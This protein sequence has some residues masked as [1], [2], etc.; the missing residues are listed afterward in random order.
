[1]SFEGLPVN[2]AVM[3]VGKKDAAVLGALPCTNALGEFTLDHPEF[4]W[5]LP[6]DIG[7]S[8]AWIM[9]HGTNK[10]L[11]RH[12]PQQPGDVSLPL[13]DG[14]FQASAL[15]PEKGLADTALLTK[16]PQHLVDGLL[17][18]FDRDL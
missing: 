7:P 3:M 10:W 12:V 11:R 6:P 9:K 15:E 13:V 16:D 1:M 18:P 8:V 14:Q 17:H 2:I 5:A 4:R